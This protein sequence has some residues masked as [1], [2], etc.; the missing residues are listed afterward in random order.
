MGAKLPVALRSFGL[1]PPF[2]QP[3]S[4]GGSR[5]HGDRQGSLSTRLPRNSVGVAG[6]ELREREADDD[7]HR[8]EPDDDEERRR[9]E[10]PRVV[11]EVGMR[12]VRMRQMRGR[13]ATP[14]PSWR[15]GYA[16]L[17]RRFLAPGRV[18]L[19]G[20][21]T[22]LV[23]GLVLPVAIG[24]GIALECEAAER[25]V[26][27]SP[28]ADE[29]WERY[30]TAV[31]EE[32]AALG[33]PDVGI[34]GELSSDLP[35]GVGLS[36]SAA[37]EVVV[38][39]GLCAVA[40]FAVER[41]ELARALRR[42]EHRAVG[43]PSGI[44]DQAASLLARADHALLLD[45]GTLAYEH[46]PLPAGLRLVVFDSGI[47]RSLEHTGYATR[48]RELEEGHPKRRRHVETENERV[49]AVV[50]ALR[51]DDRPAL[52]ALFRAGHHSLR[53]DLE[54]TTP[55]LDA[56]V[57]LAYARGAVAARLTGGGFG[58]AVIALVDEARVDAVAEAVL[59]DYAGAG[60]AYVLRASDGAR[61][62]QEA[63][64]E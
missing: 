16:S 25:T 3:L 8:R 30:V 5:S 29:G 33:R 39:L 19:I 61:E 24:L 35:A 40:D 13:D 32:L 41:L 18:N 62:L 31:E 55:E 11:L 21:Y 42:A 20:E 52:G 4:A 46:V 14:P 47:R 51:E 48:K 53:D 37:L 36:S 1:W 59:A 6:K 28:G 64:P 44:M 10:P 54:V 58:G 9:E 27:R 12:R 43:V 15:G 50:A 49:R 2:R 26:L 34:S 56:L 22:D 38:A 45:T 23:G 57:D 17:S 60:R 63:E 7:Q